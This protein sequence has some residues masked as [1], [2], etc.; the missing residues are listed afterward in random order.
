MIWFTIWIPF[1]LY[2]LMVM[3]QIL[4]VKQTSKPKY[5]TSCSVIVTHLYDSFWNYTNQCIAYH[6]YARSW[7]HN[8]YTYL[9]QWP[10]RQWIVVCANVS[11][12]EWYTM[13]MLQYNSHKNMLTYDSKGVVM[14]T[15]TIR[16]FSIKMVAQRILH[17]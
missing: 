13:Q 2:K 12:N 9:T 8:A 5:S 15:W 11:L 10:W 6:S 7:C 3:Q 1:H 14:S 17:Y 16:N 4:K